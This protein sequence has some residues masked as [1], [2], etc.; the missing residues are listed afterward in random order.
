MGEQ[1]TIAVM[2]ATGTQGGS[3]IRAMQ[4]DPE[5]G[6][7]ARA[8]TRDDSSEKAAEL[9]REGVEVVRADL[10]DPA[11]IDAALEGAYGAFCITFF[12][13]HLSP[14]KELG[15]AAVLAEATRRHGLQ[16]V[17]WSSLEDTRQF[18][19]LSDERIPT[20]EGKYKVPHC[21][22]KGEAD[23]A[24]LESG[25]PLTILRTSFY[26]DNFY[27]FGMGPTE[28][29]GGSLVFDLPLGDKRLAGIASEDIGKAAYAIFK[30]GEE[31]K[32]ATVGI[33]GAHLTGTQ[34]AES[35]TKVLGRPVEYRPVSTEEY[36][37]L[38]F[39]GA[40]DLANMFAMNQ[41]FEQ[42]YMSGRDLGFTRELNPDLQSFDQ[43]LA[44]NRPK[45]G[46]G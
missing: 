12:W 4:A 17:I 7:R 37:G 22:A 24:F 11:S 38:D 1:R 33:A 25:V 31:L 20:L 44:A 27:M 10:D 40:V 43:W 46:L 9:K 6:F 35:M 34:M 41:L 15:H 18:M 42:E 13:E 14:E 21:D 28:K 30:R 5:G 45:L 32:G 26:W 39:P 16:H 3:L 2:G 23:R 8:I 19:D 36:A 29:D